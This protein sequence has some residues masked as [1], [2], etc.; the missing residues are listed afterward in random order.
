M[1]TSKHSKVGK[2]R[3]VKGLEGEVKGGEVGG[4]VED[5]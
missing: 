5:V 2:L 4:A 3:E 1:G